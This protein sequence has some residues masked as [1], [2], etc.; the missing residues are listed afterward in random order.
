VL[1]RDAGT[2]RDDRALREALE[3]NRKVDVLQLLNV[4]VLVHEI[5]NED[6]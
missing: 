6:F 1:N 2:K 4:F 5:E 3:S